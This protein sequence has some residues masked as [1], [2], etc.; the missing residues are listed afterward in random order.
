MTDLAF[1]LRGSNLKGGDIHQ[2]QGYLMD[3][4]QQLFLDLSRRRLY[5]YLQSLSGHLLFEHLN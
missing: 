2:Q 4:Y 5:E 3:R 1:R